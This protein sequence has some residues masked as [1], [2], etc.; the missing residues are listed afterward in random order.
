MQMNNMVSVS[1]V[2]PVYNV[3]QY[4]R[5]CLDSLIAQ[6]LTEI[7]IICV[8]DGSTDSSPL[9]LEEY[10]SKDDRIKVISKQ[11]SG[12]GHT[13]NTGINAAI[14]KYIGIV[15]SDDYVPLDMY[16]RLYTT[17]ERESVDFV[18]AD[19][20]RFKYGRDGQLEKSHNRLSNHIIDYNRIIDPHNEHQVFQFIMNT[21]SGVYRRD[22]LNKYNIRHNETP[23]A[24]FQDTGFWFQTF[25]WAN[26][27]YFID[28]PLYMNRRDNP[29]S[30]VY[31]KQK[32][33]CPCNEFDFIY[34]IIK[35]NP[36]LLSFLDVFQYQR[37]K[38]YMASLNRSADDFKLEFLHRFADDFKK[39]A[40]DNELSL[41]MFPYGSKEALFLIMDN[42]EY[43]YKTMQDSAAYGKKNLVC[44]TL[45]SLEK[46]GVKNTLKRI[47]S[48]SK[49]IWR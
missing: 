37:Y 38:G 42:P 23:G 18:K 26:K 2:V 33:F 27:V 5:E 39:S 29:N 20:Y 31:N 16:E 35:D 10:A 11:N 3:E 1:I 48:K 47:I 12:Y 32:I 13:M 49:N 25:C 28:T 44:K 9:I 15:E 7:E 6:T 46:K 14:G 17:A 8:N 45:I 41:S 43:Y 21:W 4:L 22:F 19:F 40:S 30:S 24:S 36:E 34:S